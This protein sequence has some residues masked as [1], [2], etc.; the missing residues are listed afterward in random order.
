MPDVAFTAYNV[1]SPS[2]YELR[3]GTFRVAID[4]GAS[5]DEKDE[6][7]QL[8]PDALVITHGHLDHIGMVPWAMNRWKKIPV[9]ATFA[10]IKIGEWIWDDMIKVAEG[11]LRERP[12]TIDDAIHASKRM[13]KMYVGKAVR[14]TDDLTMTPFNAGHILG[15][16]GLVFTYRGE[17]YVVTG[18][19]SMHSHGYIEGAKVPEIPSCRALIRES[20]YAGQNLVGTREDIRQNFLNTVEEVLRAGGRV[21]IPTL[22]ID[23]M[24]EIY[25]LLHAAGVHERRPIW[26]VGGAKPTAVYADLVRGGGVLRTMNRFANMREQYA[27]MDRPSPKVILASSGMMAHDTASYAWGAAL[28]GDPTSAILMVNWQNPKMP[29]GAFIKAAQA[30][31]VALPEGA[32]S[33]KCLIRRF[34]FSSHAKENEMAELERAVNPT[35]IIHVHGEEERIAAFIEERSKSG[36]DRLRLQPKAWEEVGL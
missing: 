24:A 29:G 34:D 35:S 20:T 25:S 3:F 5:F 10:T 28:L 33:R 22:A 27:E 26:V 9:Y 17:H 11:Q 6:P 16:V 4:L 13:R 8:R 2:R 14:L 18:D 19:I 21:L 31:S 36:E 23:R 12:F 32:F 15:A 1:F 30:D 7:T